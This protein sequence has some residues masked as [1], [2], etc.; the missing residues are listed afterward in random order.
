MFFCDPTPAELLELRLMP[1]KSSSVLQA[2]ASTGTHPGTMGL[3][4]LSDPICVV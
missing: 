3:F 4:R 2:S 1:L